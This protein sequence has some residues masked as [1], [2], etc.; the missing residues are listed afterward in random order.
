METELE[1]TPHLA[2][3]SAKRIQLFQLALFGFPPTPPEVGVTDS[4]LWW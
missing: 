2:S 3:R 4:R 1:S